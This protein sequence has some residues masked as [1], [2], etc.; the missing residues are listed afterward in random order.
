MHPLVLAAAPALQDALAQRTPMH[1]Q[2]RSR[3]PVHLA[4]VYG[5]PAEARRTVVG[6]G[7]NVHTVE[8]EGLKGNPDETVWEQAQ[9][10]SRFFVTQDMDFS[11]SRKFVPGTHYGLLLVRLKPTQPVRSVYFAAD[12]Y[13]PITSDFEL[14]LVSPDFLAS[15]PE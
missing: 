11:D 6:G 1:L 10:E 7:H 8:E 9:R 2:Y 4:C 12:P 13:F 3:D 15:L 5:G 14:S